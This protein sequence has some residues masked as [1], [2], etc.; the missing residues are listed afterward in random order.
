MWGNV[1]S[2]CVKCKIDLEF[3]RKKG[4]ELDIGE[5]IRLKWILRVVGHEN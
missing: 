2:Y 1:A 5:R 3:G 4:R